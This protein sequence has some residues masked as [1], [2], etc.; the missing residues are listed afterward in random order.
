LH[1]KRVLISGASGGIGRQLVAAFLSEGA[2]VIAVDVSE[3]NLR[4]LKAVHYGSDLVTEK[5][6]ISNAASCEEMFSDGKEID[7]LINNAAASMGLIR[8]DHLDRLVS[9]DEVTPRVWDYFIA[10]NLSGAW[11]LTRL[12]APSMKKNG[13]GRIINVTTSFFTMLRPMFHPYGPS[14]AALEA[15]SAGH[16][17]EFAPYGITVNVVVPGGPTD[18]PMV[19]AVTKM[20]RNALISPSVMVPPMLWLCSE[21]ADKVTG[22]R[23]VAAKWDKNLSVAEAR[24]ASEARIAWPELAVSPVWPGGRPEI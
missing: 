20:D 7:I 19:P 8:D 9:I 11:Y 18:T 17:G 15:M 2:H 23:Y 10:S 5:L 1:G 3:E 13:W 21:E 12:A 4:E 14:K 24:V 16:A 22:M 6:D